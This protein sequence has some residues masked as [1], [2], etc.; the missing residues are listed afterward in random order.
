MRGI[1]KKTLWGS[2]RFRMGER[3][4]H[5]QQIQKVT[6]TIAA[7]AAGVATQRITLN[8]GTHTASTVTIRMGDDEANFGATGQTAQ[9]VWSLNGTNWVS[10]QS[11]TSSPFTFTSVPLA[12]HYGISLSNTLGTNPLSVNLYA[13]T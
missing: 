3:N 13:I 6:C 9:L 8:N 4:N 12:P 10:H 11:P 1:L 7:G 2:G 5:G